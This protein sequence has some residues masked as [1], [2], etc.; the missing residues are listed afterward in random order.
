VVL[1]LNPQEADRIREMSTKQALETIRNRIDQFGVTEPDIRPQGEDRIVIQLPGI[2]DPE[3]AVALIGQTAL[4]EFKLVDEAHSVE[5]ALQNGPPAGT[6]VAY[7]VSIDP[8]T[9]RTRRTRSCSQATVKTG[10]FARCPG[11]DRNHLTALCRPEFRRQGLPAVR[12]DHRDQRAETSGHRTDGV[13][14]SAP[15]SQE[16]IPGARPHTGSFTMKKRGTGHCAPGRCPPARSRSWKKGPSPFL[17][18]T[19]STRAFIRSSSAVLV[20]IL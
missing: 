5:E 20:L 11:H 3:R 8:Q 19:P 12:T 14:M 1:S 4:L 17:G 13:V 2:D 10:E 9:G 6:E 18:R 7:E 15:V 16:K